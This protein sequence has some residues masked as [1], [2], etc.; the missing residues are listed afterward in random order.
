MEKKKSNIGNVIFSSNEENK[1][2]S[3]QGFDNTDAILD[4]HAMRL[5]ELEEVNAYLNNIIDQKTR[6]LNELKSSGNKF[7]SILAHDLRGPF[8]SILGSLEIL[9]ESLEKFSACEIRKLIV[10]A[11]E[12]AHKTLHLLDNLLTLSSFQDKKKSINP[13][14]IKLHN[15]VNSELETAC[16]TS[17]E[18]KIKVSNLI[19]SELEVYVNPSM[20]KTIVGSLINFAANC[21]HKFGKIA[22]NAAHKDKFTEII[23]KTDGIEPLKNNAEKLFK[24]EELKSTTEIY[25]EGARLDL[26]LCKEFVELHGGNIQMKSNP[27]I[28]CEIMFTLPR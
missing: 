8:C 4:H 16:S 5:R 7:T 10:I 27:G 18:K 28:G 14:K 19:E 17:G 3:R 21:T 2:S 15:L 6:E 13:V 12:S 23:I 1:P 22:V 11:S 25:S 24:I 26:L 20:V 9:M